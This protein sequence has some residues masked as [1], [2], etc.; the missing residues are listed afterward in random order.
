MYESPNAT[1]VRLLCGHTAK[2]HEASSVFDFPDEGTYCSVCESDQPLDKT[3][4]RGLRPGDHVISF[5]GEVGQV[6]SISTGRYPKSDKVVVNS[7]EYYETVWTLI[8][9][10]STI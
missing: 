6:T 1:I 10:P 4:S 5:R 8:P 3:R 2:I 9:D 7:R